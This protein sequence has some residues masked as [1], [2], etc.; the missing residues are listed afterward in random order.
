MISP[1]GGPP[2]LSAV[3]DIGGFYHANLDEAPAQAFHTPTYGTTLDIDYAGNKPSNIVRSGYNSAAQPQ[4]QVAI[5]SNFGA[6][7]F[8]NWAAQPV[9]TAPGKIAFSADADTIL[10]SGAAGPLVSNKQANFAAV[11]SLPINSVIA[12]DKRNNTVFYG[13]SA[14]RRAISFLSISHQLIISQLLSLNK[15]RYYFC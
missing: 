9:T 3:G 10:L 6:S 11:S 1:P 12:S 15:R 8:A 13:G 14:G 5:S 7:W 4:P 2:L